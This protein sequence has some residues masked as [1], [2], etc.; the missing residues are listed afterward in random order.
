[1]KVYD[2]PANLRTQ[3]SCRRI[4]RSAGRAVAVWH[5]HQQVAEVLRKDGKFESFGFSAQ[6]KL[7]LQYYEA[8]FLLELVRIY[9]YIYMVAHT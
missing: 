6:G 4:E 2:L 1:M 5:P 9:I 7:F 3:L 8:L